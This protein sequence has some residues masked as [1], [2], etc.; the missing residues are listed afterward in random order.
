M[1]DRVDSL[2]PGDIARRA[3]ARI[4]TDRGEYAAAFELYSACLRIANDA[5]VPVVTALT[6]QNVATALAAAGHHASAATI[7][8]AVEVQGRTYPD[9]ILT[10]LK[11]VIAQLQQTMGHDE[12]E[13]HASL[14][15]EMTAD[16]LAMFAQT[17]LN[18]AIAD[19]PR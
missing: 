13:R 3:L 5:G 16:E 8:A 6:N 18:R 11:P 19:H 1:A 15:R 4:R 12:F 10:R 9:N 14:G 2:M 17:A 7:A